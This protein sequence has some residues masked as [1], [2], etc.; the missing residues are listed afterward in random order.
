MNLAARLREAPGEPAA[1]GPGPYLRLRTQPKRR[2][3]GR[4]IALLLIAASLLFTKVWERT[5]ANSLSME[6]DRLTRE[7]RSLEN[8]IRITR[9]LE[10]QAAFKSGVDLAG[11]GRLGFQNPD[12]AHVV[13]VDLALPSARRSLRPA[14]GARLLASVRK[15]LPSF[16]TE[17]VVGLPAAAVDAGGT[18]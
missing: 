8:R 13:D 3:S 12:P 11:L 2:V 9:D 4:A 10:E 18:R 6:R 1:Q 7:V 5:V 16:W 17:R 15:A 14:L